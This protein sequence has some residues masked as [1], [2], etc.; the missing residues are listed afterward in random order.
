MTSE[1]SSFDR[2][3]HQ[4]I[5]SRKQ[6]LQPCCV[7]TSGLLPGYRRKGA[8][9]PYG[10]CKGSVQ[11]LWKRGMQLLAMKPA[12]VR[13]L[14]RCYGYHGRFRVVKE[15]PNDHRVTLKET[16]LKCYRERFV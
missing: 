10:C 6:H 16:A 3:F 2:D 4:A 12:M 13:V 8:V 1:S 14:L 7:I 15:H 5:H 9:S 11:Q